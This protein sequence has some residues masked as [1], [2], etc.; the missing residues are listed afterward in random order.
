MHARS[1]IQVLEKL[2]QQDAAVQDWKAVASLSVDPALKRRANGAIQNAARPLT[3]DAVNP[4]SA[5]PHSQPPGVD[6]RPREL[7]T[8]IRTAHTYAS[9]ARP[10]TVQAPPAAAPLFR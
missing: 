6:R 8:P 9:Q 5:R 3:S 4:A 1:C 2:G 10:M 7:N